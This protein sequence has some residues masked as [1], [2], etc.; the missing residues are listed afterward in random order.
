MSLFRGEALTTA[1]PP[2]IRLSKSMS[3]LMLFNWALSP[4]N[5]YNNSV[6]KVRMIAITTPL[7]TGVERD[8]CA[9]MRYYETRFLIIEK[10]A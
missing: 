6:G 4:L 2:G 9:V 5:E 1:R 8:A 7:L 10:N 3:D